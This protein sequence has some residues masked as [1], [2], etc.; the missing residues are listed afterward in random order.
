MHVLFLPLN[1]SQKKF[2]DALD[3]VYKLNRFP[4]RQERMRRALENATFCSNLEQEV[5]CV[6]LQMFCKFNLFFS[7]L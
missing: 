4:V 2:R 7:W 5:N 1:N 6:S 3:E